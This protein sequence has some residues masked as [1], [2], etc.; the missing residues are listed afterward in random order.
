MLRERGIRRGIEVYVKNAVDPDEPERIARVINTYPPPS[1][2]LVVQYSDGN[3]QEVEAS[4]VTTMFEKN[5]KKA[6]FF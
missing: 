6:G 4:Q 3:M 1:S 2:W 5:R